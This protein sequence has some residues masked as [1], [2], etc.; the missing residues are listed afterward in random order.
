MK[1]LSPAQ[2]RCVLRLSEAARLVGFAKESAEEGH[3]KGVEEFIRRAEHEL[4]MARTEVTA[5]P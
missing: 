4:Y 5:R 1:T 2:M 3:T